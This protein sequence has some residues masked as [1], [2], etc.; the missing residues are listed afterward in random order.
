MDPGYDA[1]GAELDDRGADAFVHVGNCDADLRYLTRVSGPDR[2]YA[3]VYDGEPILC[4][5]W[6]FEEQAREAF[7]GRVVTADAATTAGDRAAD[8]LDGERVLVPRQVPHDAAIWLERAGCD[9]ES[10]DVV[11]RIRARKTEAE[12]DRIR[13]VQ[14]A[15]RAGMARAETVLAEASVDG[16]HVVSDDEPLTVE[17]LRRA[18]NATLASEGV[19]AAGNTAIR[20]GSTPVPS[21]AE[22]EIP[23]DETVVISLSPRG[24]WGYHGALA[25]TFVVESE[26]G[27][28]RRASVAVESARRAGLAEI[29]AGI[30]VRS[31]RDEIV[32][33][34]GA[35]GFDAADVPETV[36]GVGLAR[37]EA[38]LMGETVPSRTVVALAPSVVDPAEGTVAVA[39][40]VVVDDG[41]SVLG[42]YPLGIT[43][44][45]G[46]G[47]DS[48][49]GSDPHPRRES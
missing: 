34:I 4:V 23:P 21:G 3:F 27:W 44:D 33:E 13:A 8:L 18:V 40:L 49:P 9:L 38:P 10:T 19:T 36:R 12:I 28:E 24:P 6:R 43:P 1:L 48:D 37:R 46:S 31:V 39:D 14:R 5:P 42:E 15:A 25:R 35:F 22:R 7:P 47:F 30:G 11:A 41:P 20:V 26:G 45:P 16:E 17:R 2:D 29:E 32:A